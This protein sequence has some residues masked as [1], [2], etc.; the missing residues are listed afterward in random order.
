MIEFVRRRGSQETA[1]EV[2]DESLQAPPRP[3]PID[4]ET[5]IVQAKLAVGPA[6]DRFEQE[7]DAVAERVVR[8]LAARTVDSEV[9]DGR[10]GSEVQSVPDPAA[11]PA[12]KVQR[13]A[14]ATVGLDGGDLDRST[15]SKIQAAR[16]GGTAMPAVMRSRMEGAFGA[17]FGGVRVHEGSQ[18]TALNDSI[19]AKAFTVGNDIFFRDKMPD[20][21]SADGQRLVA[22]E[23]TH[24]IQQGASAQRTVQRKQLE[25]DRAAT[26]LVPP[27][28]RE[29]RPASQ[30]QAKFGKKVKSF[31]KKV[32]SL[33]GKASKNDVVDEAIESPILDDASHEE[34][35]VH[36]RQT[37]GSGPGE[38]PDF[39][40]TQLWGATP[41]GFRITL[42]VAQERAGWMSDVDAL[43]KAA[44]SNPSVLMKAVAGENIQV[45]D[46]SGDGTVSNDPQD[47]LMEIAL[48]ARNKKLVDEGLEQ[49]TLE[50]F[51]DGIHEVGHT[52]VRLDTLV[53][54][55][56]KERYSYGMWPQKVYDPS[57]GDNE[58]GYAGFIDAGPGEVRHPDTEHEGDTLTAY[59]DYNV[60]RSQWNKAH[61]LAVKRFNNPPPY[62]LTGYNCTA[63]AREITLAGGGSYPG[64][65]LLPGFG[66]TPGNLYA[67]ILK[68]TMKNRPGA[69]TGSSDIDTAITSRIDERHE[70]WGAA[71]K[72]A[73][74][75]KHDDAMERRRER[76]RQA[77]AAAGPPMLSLKSYGVSGG[78]RAP[79]AGSEPTGECTFQDIQRLIDM[80]N[81]DNGFVEV[82][83]FSSGTFYWVLESEYQLLKTGG[84]VAVAPEP[85]VAARVSDAVTEDAEDVVVE[86]MP[87]PT[88]LQEIRGIGLSGMMAEMSFAILDTGSY[89][90][91][92]DDVRAA[93]RND[94]EARARELSELLEGD[95]ALA[96][97]ILGT[98]G[99][100]R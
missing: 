6:G 47:V 58:G 73:A 37:K 53:H 68:R 11:Q 24:T 10:P 3:E 55:A 63:F 82:Q 28:V 81:S 78:F 35:M 39:S 100:E 98:W 43:K 59:Q 26:N 34:T 31:G 2:E 51:T 18:S 16:G 19:Q 61:K 86:R 80:G 40:N 85:D 70:A 50:D 20:A 87:W 69:R 84:V 8:S 5:T 45:P 71:G 79:D 93:L 9:T 49:R 36:A 30:V 7:A 12:P 95:D 60:G 76:E 41:N 38:N 72:Q 64:S 96:S 56:V 32:K 62:V 1:P 48:R 83:N 13:A 97:V 74:D 57:S 66:Y 42:A 29:H 90:I 44:L 77:R 15:S 67:M 21:S 14:A 22:H 23:L 88:L 92:N 89:D 46:P 94:T 65:G 17:D 25:P 54:G 91:T 52:W 75:D 27:V 99:V 4:V 33:L